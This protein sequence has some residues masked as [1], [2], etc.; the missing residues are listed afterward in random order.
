M[1]IWLTGLSG[2]G[3]TTLANQFKGTCVLLDADILRKGLCADLGYS[4]IDRKENIRRIAEVAK[5][6]NDNS[7]NVIVSIISPFE[8]DRKKARALIG[9]G[10]KEVFVDCPLPICERRDV[11]GL[12]SKA[13]NGEIKQFTGIDSIYE[14]PENPDLVLDTNKLSIKECTEKICNILYS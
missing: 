12:Y 3:K 13:R 5:I 2:S 1:V 4:D 7:L 10:F 11:K 6:F 8:V 9:E 14:I